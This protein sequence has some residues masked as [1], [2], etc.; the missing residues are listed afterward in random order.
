MLTACALRMSAQNQSG[1]E[2]HYWTLTHAADQIRRRKV[3]SEELTRL[4][5]DRIRKYD[6]KLNTFITLTADSALRQARECDRDAERGVWRGPLHGVPFA[7]KDNID[8]AGL[9]TTAASKVFA[10]RLPSED[11]EVAKRIFR[12]GV[13]SLGKLNLDE[14][15]F[16]GSG[17][18]GSFGPS[19]NPW[20]PDRI[21][22]GSSSGSAAA[23][24]AGLCYGSVGTDDG[25]SIRIPASHCG[26]VGLKTSYGRVSTRGIVP[27]A[28]SLD[29][30]GP[31][32]RSVEDA[33]LLTGILAGYDPL[34]A[35]VLD[36]P[37]P[38]YAKAL[39]ASVSQL[40]IGVPR[41]YF[42][43]DLDP[44]VASSVEAAIAH[45]KKRVRSVKDLVLPRFEFVEGGGTDIELYHYHREYFE[46][47]RGLY[48]SYSQR[49][50]DRAKTVSADR[51][52]ETL[53]RIR[54]ARRDVRRTFEDVDVLML[55]SM[56][57]PAPPLK[58]VMDRTHRSRASNLSA[59]NRFGL[60]AMSVPCGFSRDGLPI[61]LQIVGP[62]FDE[63]RVLTVGFAY[64]ESTSHLL[65]RAA[66]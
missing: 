37:V 50:L 12:A 58:A 46:K 57:E 40:R 5:L 1:I 66:P 3:S 60:P 42:F 11:A 28:Y 53:K 39:R 7:L 29:S 16:A 30:V 4:C 22:G 32:V 27:S 17:T 64:Q 9:L 52:V 2:P 43:E 20:N 19:R 21:T 55:P 45:M 13:V 8:T 44:D 47:S 63:E 33:A 23:L 65:T 61:G 59:F 26:V 56:R 54:E 35:I 48:G 49:L 51:Y 25:G 6:G 34:D 24:A 15:A 62:Y 14:F 18:T 31:T 38:D 10:D 36:R 41:D